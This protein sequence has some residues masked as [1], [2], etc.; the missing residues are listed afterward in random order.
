MHAFTVLAYVRQPDSLAAFTVFPVWFWGGIGLLM[1]VFAFC[2]LRAPLSLFVTAVWAVT[3]S[4]A[5]DDA[6]ALSNFNHP[7]ITAG[8]SATP[9]GQRIIR[10]ATVNCAGFAFGDFDLLFGIGQLFFCG[11]LHVVGP[12]VKLGAGFLV[13]LVVVF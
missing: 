11:Q 8:R 1:S 10:V 12:A 5:M 9:D 2:F 7:K 4:V 3:L 6:K 13:M